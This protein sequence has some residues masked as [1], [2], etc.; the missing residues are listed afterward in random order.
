MRAIGINDF[1]DR[2]F[3]SFPFE[4]K[5]AASLGE[6]EV[7]F[8][9]LI[10]GHPK[11][12]KT[13]FCIQLAKYMSQFSRV[14]FNSVEQG[15][16]KTLQDALK[17]NNMTDVNGRVVFGNKES[18]SE[19]I[20][21]LKKKNSPMIVFLDSRDYMNLTA[22]QWF[23]LTETFPRK[24]FLLVSWESAGKPASKYAKDIA[25]KVDIII[26]VKNFVAYPRSRFGG[27]E[28]YIIW[29]RQPAAGQQLKLAE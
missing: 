28:K 18:Y 14:Y 20:E 9:A 26:H 13:E 24:C 7:N 27:N 21:R 19:M 16:S 25:F 8:S 1:L 12:G 22:K 4:G 5:F 29:D 11:N 6:P 17:R 23:N 2:N 15:I 3:T 10:F